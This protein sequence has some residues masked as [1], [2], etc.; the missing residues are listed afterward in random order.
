MS[1][2]SKRKGNSF[3]RELVNAARAAGL[4]AERAYA[5]N[6]KSLGHAEDVDCVIGGKRVQAKR[7]KALASYLIPSDTVDLV[8]FREDRGETFVLLRFA[9]WLELLRS[10]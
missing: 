1:H 10:D 6:G 5:S 4:T 3:E 9:D 7:R 8:A 2:P